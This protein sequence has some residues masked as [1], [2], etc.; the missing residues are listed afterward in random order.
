MPTPT[1]AQKILLETAL[2]ELDNNGNGTK[3]KTKYKG[4][5]IIDDDDVKFNPKTD[6]KSFSIPQG[7]TYEHAGKV[8]QRKHEEMMKVNRFIEIFRYRP[9]DGAH[10]CAIVMRRMFGITIGK[11]TQTMFGTQ[12]PEYRS[13]DISHTEKM[14]VP[15]GKVEIPALPGADVNLTATD[16][17][18]GPVF[19]IFIDSPK[20][21]K[22]I[23]ERF[24]REINEE[25]R[26]N[27]IYR[28]KALMGAHSLKFMDVDSFRADEIVFSE[29]VQTNLDGGVFSVLEYGNAL[30]A[31]NI[32]LKRTALLYGQFGT[33][34]SS[35]G[36]I[37][38]QKA[39]K[40][41]WT[42]LSAR[43]GR[44]S[45]EPVIQTAALYEPAVIFVE[46]IDAHTPA[47]GDKPAVARLLDLFDGIGAKNSKLL[48]VM[49]SN[50]IEDVPA[51][52]LRPGRLDYCISIEGLDRQGVERLMRAV[53]PP[54]LLADDIDF[55][56]VHSEME[57]FLPAWVK[58]TSERAKSFAIVRTKGELNF[59]LT[60]DDLVAAARSLHSQLELMRAANEGTP[61]VELHEAF[62]KLLRQSTD[63]LV[64]KDAEDDYV[65]GTIKLPAGL[66]D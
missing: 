34:K 27:S 19:A 13:I 20:M 59:Q 4:T 42:F 56:A 18:Y 43:A 48:V 61:V 22:Q 7:M 24:F 60:T 17:E 28:G 50:H 32:K 16:G 14:E 8:F 23:I 1:A 41:G 29:E 11:D 54:H 52:M 55:D 9:D 30:Q 63:G 65:T 64:I 46:D 5:R 3:A 36:L 49:T 31:A 2:A 51:G 37:T 45:L 66:N 6:D 44:D 15:W 47:E 33:G 12:P 53:T 10:A 35:V 39:V 21:H 26:T 58:A 38:A 40:N 62:T 57:G 25:L